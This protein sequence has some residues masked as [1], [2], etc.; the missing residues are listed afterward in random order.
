MWICGQILLRKILTTY[1]QAERNKFFLNIKS[2]KL[3]PR[4]QM[5]NVYGTSLSERTGISHTE[6]R[7]AKRVSLV[8]QSNRPER[9]TNI[10]DRGSR[11]FKGLEGYVVPSGYRV[12][13]VRLPHLSRQVTASVPKKTGNTFL[14]P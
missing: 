13:P 6:I 9:G 7:Q 12:C 14:K 8:R 10:I 5:W 2:K 11:I 1:P 4:L 3:K